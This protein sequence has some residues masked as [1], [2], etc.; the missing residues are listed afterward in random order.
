MKMVLSQA[1]SNKTIVSFNNFRLL[2]ID[3]ELSRHIVA[4]L[5]VLGL[6]YRPMVGTIEFS[7]YRHNLSFY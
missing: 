2:K 7:D 5:L 1:A 6:L 4:F 3:S